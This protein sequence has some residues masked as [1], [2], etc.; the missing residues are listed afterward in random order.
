MFLGREYN[1]VEMGYIH[2]YSWRV[3][4]VVEKWNVWKL[5]LKVELNEEKER[6][7]ERERKERGAEGGGEY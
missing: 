1:C 4:V 6:E 7:R 5:K 2:T 3:M